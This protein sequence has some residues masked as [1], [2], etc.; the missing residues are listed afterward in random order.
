M[1]SNMCSNAP[2]WRPGPAP[3]IAGHGAPA[4]APDARPVWVHLDLLFDHDA[5]RDQAVVDG[6]DL[7]GRTR[8]MLLGWRRGS[9]GDWLGIV[10]YQIHYADGRPQ[11]TLWSDQLVP[12][13]ALSKRADLAPLG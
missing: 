6:L 1:M 5:A 13:T 11:P 12:V 2:E 10:T 4:V 7:T 9:R 3:A 8:G